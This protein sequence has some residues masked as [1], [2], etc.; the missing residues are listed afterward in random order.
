MI[1]LTS[2]D[3]YHSLHSVET[4]YLDQLV[5]P[6]VWVMLW[7]I[8]KATLGKKFFTSKFETA[9]V[10]FCVSTMVHLAH[11]VHGTNGLRKPPAGVSAS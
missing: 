11:L 4:F 1:R 6:M 2:N 3:R 10:V 9:D 5:I 8:Q 7:I